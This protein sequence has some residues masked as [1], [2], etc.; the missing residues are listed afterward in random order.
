MNDYSYMISRCEALALVGRSEHRYRNS[1]NIR[2]SKTR[3]AAALE[4]STEV[5]VTHFARDSQ[6]GVD[7]IHDAAA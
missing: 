7:C 2:A 1:Q 3:A 6:C 4:R 5:R